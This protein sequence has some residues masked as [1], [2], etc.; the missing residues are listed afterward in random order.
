MHDTCN[1]DAI[2][3]ALIEL[4]GLLNSPRQDEVLLGAAGVSLDRALFP[5]LVRLSAAP[6]MSVAQLAEKAGRD[7]STVSRQIAKLERLGLVKRP[8]SE[9]DMRVRAAAITK[10]GARAVAA[11]AKARRQLLGELIA[12]WP[13]AEQEA[14]PVLLRKFAEAMKERQR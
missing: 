11:I 2:A 12:D 5:L 6:A 1:V 7:P 9:E 3:A 13:A 4:T 8:S 14:F 10:A